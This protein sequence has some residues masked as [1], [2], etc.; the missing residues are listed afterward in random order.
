MLFHLL[1]HVDAAQLYKLEQLIEIGALLKGLNCAARFGHCLFVD[2]LIALAL[3]KILDPLSLLPDDVLQVFHTQCLHFGHLYQTSFF[4]LLPEFAP[5]HPNVPNVNIA[6]CDLVV[7]LWDHWLAIWL[8]ICA[9]NFSDGFIMTYA[10]RRI[11]AKLWPYWVSYL[12]GY[13]VSEPEF[14]VVRFN[15][16]KL[17]FRFGKAHK[18]SAVPS[19]IKLLFSHQ[20]VPNVD[21]VRYIDIGFIAGRFFNLVWEPLQDFKDFARFDSV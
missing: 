3:W 20:V 2:W 19:V 4:Q 5:E 11:V 9:C 1:Y 7:P 8:V 12:V 17:P 10:C 14:T 16:D 21:L 6:K 15:R 13:F 18:L